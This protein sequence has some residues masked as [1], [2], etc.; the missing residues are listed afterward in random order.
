MDNTIEENRLVFTTLYNQHY[1]K[2]LTYVIRRVQD[3]ETA[4]DICAE[5]FTVCWKKLKEVPEG[6]PALLWLYGVARLE[7]YD[8]YR[9]G[10]RRNQLADK[11]K[12]NI[13]FVI[14]TAG[15]EMDLES[16]SYTHL[17]LPTICS[18]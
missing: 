6:K 15:F 13:A 11:I 10:S 9:K 16:V 12:D 1:H 18:V 4:A 7:V 3:P 14:S 2:I 8:S 5:V 17:T